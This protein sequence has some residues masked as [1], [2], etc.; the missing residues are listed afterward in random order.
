MFGR[1]PSNL[2]IGSDLIRVSDR[3]NANMSTSSQKAQESKFLRK[4]KIKTG[5]QT[6]NSKKV[7]DK[8]M[9]NYGSEVEVK[10]SRKALLKLKKV[11]VD[12]IMSRNDVDK[13]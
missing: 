13:L 2:A 10:R 8:L 12:S 9:E 6:S 1:I 3:T 7:S 11:G 4:C 5:H